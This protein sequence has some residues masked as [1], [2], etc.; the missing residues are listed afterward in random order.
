MC[1]MPK[2]SQR[3]LN[4]SIYEQEDGKFHFSSPRAGMDME[5]TLLESHK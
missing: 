2:C 4:K 1:N 5:V 3:I